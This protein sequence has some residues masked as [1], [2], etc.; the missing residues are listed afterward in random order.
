[1]KITRQ[2]FQRKNPGYALLIT[3]VFIGIALL[4]LGS[5]M[6]WSNS[7]AKQTERNNLFSMSTGAAEAATERVIAQ[8][9]RD[10]YNQALNAA[11]NYMQAS[12]LPTTTAWP[13]Q[14]SF[15][16]PFNNVG[17]AYVSTLPA[18]WTT[19]FVDINSFNSEY[20]GLHAYVA[21]CTVSATAT[22][23]NQPYDVSATV[24]QQFQLA[25]I[26]I[27][28]FAI[29]YNLNMEVDPGAA[30]NITGP[31]FSNGGIWTA[32]STLDYNSSVEATGTVDTNLADP[33]ASGKTGSGNS[34]FST[35]YPPVSGANTL[36]LPINTATSTND[37]AAV[38]DLLNLPPSGTDPYSSTGQLYFA[39][40]AN[41]IIS[42]SSS[43]VVSAYFQDT[44]NVEPLQPIPYDVTTI[45]QNGSTYTTN[46]SYS[47]V[48][49]A[50]FY[51]FREKKTANTVQLNVGALNSWLNSTNGSTFNDQMN[52]D[53]GHNIDS[54]Y[55]YNGAPA[56]S[57]TLPSVR[58]AN[59]ATL[60][61]SGLT[62]VTPDPLYVLG[63]Y[64]AN[65]PS[66][67]NGANVANTA[68]AALIGDAITVLSPSWSDS[69]SLAN[70]TA[71]NPN[72][73]AATATTVNAATFE[74]IVPSTGNNY[75]GGVENFLRLLEN[76]SGKTLTYNGSIVV[77]FP[78]QYATNNWVYGGYYTAPNRAWAFD[79]NFMSQGGLPPLTPQIRT[80][81]R[82]SWTVE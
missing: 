29:F 75:S 19:N 59:G 36:A 21:Q 1:M 49:N 62:V 76:W 45:T 18:N 13:V 14:F 31:V 6:D 27:F 7:T 34:T 8:M 70:K 41:I 81:V 79:V 63:N 2:L 60:P 9:S 47:F 51:D 74:G 72:G 58:V 67:N 25:A 71:T 80:L 39:N 32:S 24:H 26:P 30:M 17:W 15:G 40:Q 66:L 3:I 38:R 78:S 52:Y 11:T 44:N 35:N 54:V 5:V 53:T 33:Y 82:Q 46:Q 16:N 10:F 56:S 23:V 69:Y 65:G 68:P 73:R 22:T 57:T 20:A 77:M 4:L 43:G 28:Q 12:L 37:P 42:N 55:V 48:T 50:S 64:N 61:S